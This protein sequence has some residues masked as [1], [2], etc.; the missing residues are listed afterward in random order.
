MEAAH[1]MLE[2][3]H[4]MHFI[5]LRLIQRVS[6]SLSN[7]WCVLVNHMSGRL[8]QY[9]C[10]ACSHPDDNEDTNLLSNLVYT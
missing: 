2:S 1:H 6:A 7:H 3:W 8:L 5:A 9:V 10:C 4:N